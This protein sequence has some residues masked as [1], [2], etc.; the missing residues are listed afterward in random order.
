M[1]NKVILNF[2]NVKKFVDFVAKDS[3][4]IDL[5]I[6]SEGVSAKIQILFDENILELKN[7]D[8]LVKTNETIPKTMPPVHK[9]VVKN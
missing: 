7:G 2:D 5:H 3:E 4:T 1:D 6:S 9:Y 8:C